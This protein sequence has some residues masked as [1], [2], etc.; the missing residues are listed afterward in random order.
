MSGKNIC[1]LMLPNQLNFINGSLYSSWIPTT[2]F[3][4]LEVFIHAN[5]M[6]WLQN[7]LLFTAETFSLAT[8]PQG[9]HI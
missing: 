4:Q 6:N 1:I 8:W 9:I 5:P 3:S 2:Y 7:M